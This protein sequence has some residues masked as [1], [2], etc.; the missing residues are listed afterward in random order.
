MFPNNK[1]LSTFIQKMTGK[2]TR[3]KE[4]FVTKEGANKQQQKHTKT[5]QIKEMN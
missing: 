4:K 5:K 2:L 1:L 3:S